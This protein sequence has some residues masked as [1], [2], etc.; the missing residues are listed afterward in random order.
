MHVFVYRR[1]I[2]GR[3][4]PVIASRPGF[5][6]LNFTT[7][8]RPPPATRRNKYKLSCHPCSCCVNYQTV[9]AC[10][11]TTWNCL[12]APVNIKNL[13]I[14]PAVSGMPAS[15]SIA[16]VKVNARNGFFLD[17]PLKLS[18]LSLPDCCWTNINAAKAIMDAIE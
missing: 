11:N 1:L 5:P 8:G 13:P 18:K 16:M 12:K 2:L 7:A 10:T 3:A 4:I 15:D 14:K 6:R 9:G 17:K